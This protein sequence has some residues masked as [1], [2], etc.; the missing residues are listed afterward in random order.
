MIM[1]SEERERGESISPIFISEIF[2][3]GSNTTHRERGH[4]CILWGGEG[5]KNW[6]QLRSKQ[7]LTPQMR[8][9]IWPFDLLLS[10][11]YYWGVFKKA[12]ESSYLEKLHRRCL[13]VFQLPAYQN[14]Y[15]ISL[16]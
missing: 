16:N 5:G 4:K 8:G 13:Y 12:R 6:D 9:Q 1:I 11:A 7:L 3:A 14:V 2:K 10:A 15:F